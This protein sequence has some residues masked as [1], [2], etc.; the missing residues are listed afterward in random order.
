M[1]DWEHL[2]SL[3]STKLFYTEGKFILAELGRMDHYPRK[4]LDT[5]MKRFHE[6]G[7]DHCDPIAEYVLIDVCLHGMI[8]ISDESGEFVFLFFFQVDGGH[9]TTNKLVIETSRPSSLIRSMPKKRPMIAVVERNKRAKVSNSKKLYYSKGGTRKFHV[10]PHLSC[11]AKKAA[12]LLG[13][14]GLRIMLSAS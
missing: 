11:G 5:Y 8:E 13:E 14:N 1:H 10:L 9:D 2:A 12:A 6:K 7:L 4:D 3:F